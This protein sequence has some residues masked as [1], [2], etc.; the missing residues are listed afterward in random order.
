LQLRP[1]PPV[2]DKTRP[3]FLMSRTE[4]LL[5]LAGIIFFFLLSYPIMQIFNLQTPVLEVPL[6][7]LYL[8]FVWILGIICL[9]LFGLWLRS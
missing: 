5:I 6:A 2:G 8:F 3:G 1:L 7:I 4:K 9:F